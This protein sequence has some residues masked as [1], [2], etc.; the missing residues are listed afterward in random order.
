M[1]IKEIR[2]I[3]IDY[4][5]KVEKEIKEKDRDKSERPKKINS[6]NVIYWAERE[7][8]RLGSQKL[9]VKRLI[10]GDCIKQISSEEYECLPK[11]YKINY[12]KSSC[13]CQS[14]QKSRYCEHILAVKLFKFMEEWNEN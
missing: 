14:F 9:K 8:I 13:S 2:P 5:K 4:K 10:E 12:G 11:R 3:G 1:V 7:G 6:K